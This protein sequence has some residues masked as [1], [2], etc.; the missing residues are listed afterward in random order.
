[1]ATVLRMPGVSADANEADLLEWAVS[2][3]DSVKRGDVVATVETEK[4]VV[5]LEAEE[6]GVLFKTLAS[7]GESV[8]IGGPI[9]IFV[10]QGEEVGDEEAVLAGLGLGPQS[11]G[12]L[13]GVDEE[14]SQDALVPGATLAIE[15]TADGVANGRPGQSRTRIFAS[16]LVRRLAGEAGI[17]LEELEGSGPSGRIRRRDLELA[18]SRRAAAPPVADSG[19]PDA[20]PPATS[21]PPA[22]A[23]TQP[24]ASSATRPAEAGEFTDTAHTKFRRAVATALTSSKQNVPHFYLKATCAVDQLL[25]LRQRVNADGRVK[26]TINDFL[27]KA[28]ALAM[29][30][31]PEMNVVWTPEAV[32]RFSSVDIAVAMATERGLMTPVVRS[33]ESRSLSDLSAAV[34]DLGAR[35]G[36]GTLKQHEL[37]GGTLTISNLGMFGTEEFAAIINPPQVGIL[38]VGAV[39]AQPVEVDGRLELGR[40]IKVVLSVD[41]RPVDG[42]LAARWLRSFQQ[43]VQEPLQLLV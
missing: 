20:P 28:A 2:P 18:L 12:P 22:A 19:G 26:I 34:K 42:A 24:D 36:A 10:L 40:C 15:H 17:L 31:V 33:V 35:A 30:E 4:A 1:M 5:D 21:L 41:H 32:R 14:R 9:A 8:A 16:P 6:D 3:G 43:L 13:P 7:P 39:T 11:S 38:A 29:V 25:E 37:E 27:V 23:P